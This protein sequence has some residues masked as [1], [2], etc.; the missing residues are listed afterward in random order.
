M[1]YQDYQNVIIERKGHVGILTVNRPQKLNAIDQQTAIEFCNAMREL[2][3]DKEVRAI[4]LRAAGNDFGSGEDISA[5]SYNTSPEEGSK[6]GEHMNSIFDIL[7]TTYKP[8]I[9]AF[10]GRAIGG[11]YCMLLYCDVIVASEDASFTS[12]TI[13]LGYTNVWRMKRMERFV[14]T[15]KAFE[16]LMSGDYI[17]AI[18]LERYGFVNKVVRREKLD[19]AAMEMAERFASKSPLAMQVSKEGWLQA[20]DMS[21]RDSELFLL[22]LRESR[23]YGSEDFKEGLA[24][25]RE[26][27]R[28]VWKGR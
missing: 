24:A 6:F 21:I 12:G 25:I 27:R 16:W 7:D 26:K 10:Q 13:N 19:E 22:T 1:S 23:L 14:G 11:S 17:P 4:I 9:A 8:L 2:N 3:G 18:E 20:R 28:P 5:P 15:K